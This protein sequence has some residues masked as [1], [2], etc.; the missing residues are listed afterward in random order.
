M[1]SVVH[2]CDPRTRV[3]GRQRELQA[4][5]ARAE[6]D[7]PLACGDGV[8]DAG[9]VVEI[10]QCRDAAG[11]RVVGAGDPVC[12]ARDAVQRRDV[13]AGSGGEHDAVVGEPPAIAQ[14]GD[15]CGAIELADRDAGDDAAAGGFDSGA[16]GDGQ[17]A[18]L[19]R[20]D[21]VLGHQHAVVGIALLR[22]DHGELD[23]PRAY[24]GDEV[25][26]EAC[27]D[28]SVA[29]HEHAERGFGHA[30]FAS[31]T[32]RTRTAPVLNSGIA[33]TGSTASEV[34]TL[35][36]PSPAKWKGTKTSPGRTSPESSAFAWM[37]PRSLDSSTVS[38]SAI[39]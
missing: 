25:L 27:A 32:R 29:D 13:R 23:V 22:A 11:E 20:T 36:V 26:G 7:D 12:R 21:G 35:A 38:P 18:A 37:T 30:T 5:H 34:S 31:S 9:G 39:P 16:I 24:G 2:D 15:P 14:N 33:D 6:D 28:R 1:R 4:E 8:A 3:R 19:H 10:T 17:R